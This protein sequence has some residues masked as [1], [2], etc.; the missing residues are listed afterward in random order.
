MEWLVTIVVATVGA[1]LALPGVARCEEPAREALRYL[2]D[3]ISRVDADRA[4]HKATARTDRM[5]QDH[6]TWTVTEK[7]K[8]V[9]YKFRRVKR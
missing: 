9:E 1:G 8:A 3:E 7:G 4:T 6:F 2:E 5:E